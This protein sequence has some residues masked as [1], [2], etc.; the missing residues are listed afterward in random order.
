M[1]SKQFLFVSIDGLITDIAWR[2][3]REGHDVR[4][5]VETDYARDVGDGFVSKPS[6]WRN[7]LEWAD[8]VVFDDTW[9]GGEE[10]KKLRAEGVPVIGGTSFTDRLE[11]DRSLANDTMADLGLEVIRGK[12]FENYQPALNYVRDHPAPYVI[13]PCG[14]VQNFKELLYVGKSDDGRDVIGVLKR[15]REKWG[16]RIE[17]FLLQRRV[18]GI[19]ISVCG[20]F[21]G[22]KFIEPVNYTFEHKP[23]FP[24]G[25]GPMTGEMGTSMFWTEP[26][27]LFEETVRPFAPLLR[28]EGY[29]G[30][31]DINCIVTEESIKPLEVTPRFGYPQISIQEEGMKT[32]VSQLL[33][34]LARG[35]DPNLEVHTGFQVGARICVPPFPYDDMDAFDEQSRNAPIWFDHEGE[36]IPE[37]I[38]LEDLKHTDGEYRIAGETG[39]ILV[40]TGKGPTMKEAQKN[41]YDLTDSV[42]APNMYYR[43]DIGD[44]W[45]DEGDLL[46]SW[47]YI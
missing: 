2:V 17:Q 18:E 40:M 8:V 30:P 36:G 34:D 31:F 11:E 14:E 29:H 33:M 25:V 41:M 32:P 35:R 42:I 6:S 39:E 16:D 22:N 27:H 46:Q 15:Y 13:K 38:H 10:A 43:N 4:Y 3:S 28:E 47:G 9:G 44:R 12:T 45:F 21:N 26:T 20:F 5:Y 7:H 19:E 1:T 23:L 24:G 37:G